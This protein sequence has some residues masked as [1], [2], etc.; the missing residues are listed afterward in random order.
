MIDS[1]ELADELLDALGRYDAEAVEKLVDPGLVHWINLTQQEQGVDG[2]LATLRLESKTV[3]DATVRIR[4]RTRTADGFVA[5][6]DVDGTTKLGASFHIPVCLVVAVEGDRIT[7]IDEYANSDHV[8]P[9][10][11]ELLGGVA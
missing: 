8:E 5:Q 2:L 3:A 7:R 4:R 10:L 1:L 6:F 9:L 11:A